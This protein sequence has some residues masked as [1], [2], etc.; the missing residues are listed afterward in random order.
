M[1]HKEF[2]ARRPSD[3]ARASLAL[4][5][6]ILNRPMPVQSDWSSKYDSQTLITLS[7]HLHRPSTVLFRKYASPRLARVSTTLEE[8]LAR[9]A[10]VARCN[11]APPTP[12]CEVQANSLSKPNAPITPTKGQQGPNMMNGCL[13]PPI[14]PTNAEG[15]PPGNSNIGAYRPITPSSSGHHTTMSRFDV[16]QVPAPTY[17]LPPI[18]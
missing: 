13:T 2:I 6:C 3:M 1:F 5:R 4:A 18:L 15:F 17:T 14:T 10:S 7:Q 8:F 16:Y 12:P 11:V 9:Q